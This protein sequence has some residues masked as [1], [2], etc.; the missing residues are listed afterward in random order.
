MAVG[1][2]SDDKDHRMKRKLPTLM[3][4]L[5]FRGTATVGCQDGGRTVLCD[6]L[7]VIAKRKDDDRVVSIFCR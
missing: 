1:W 4:G 3:V 7:R 6:E 5:F 2:S